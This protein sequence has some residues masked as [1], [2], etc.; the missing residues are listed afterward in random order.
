MKTD[1]I[2]TLL[3]DRGALAPNFNCHRR[4]A[5]VQA[6]ADACAVSE[7]T[8]YKRLAQLRRDARNEPIRVP[9]RGFA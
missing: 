6:V 9:P 2:K 1:D 3:K 7:S 5:I 8:V 4:R